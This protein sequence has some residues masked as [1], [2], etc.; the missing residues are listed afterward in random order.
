MFFLLNFEVFLEAGLAL[1]DELHIAGVLA[2]NGIAFPAFV[3]ISG[4]LGYS[5][6][7]TANLARAV[8]LDSRKAKLKM[9]AFVLVHLFDPGCAFAVD[10]FLED[11][12]LPALASAWR[13]GLIKDPGLHCRLE[14]TYL[15]LWRVITLD[16]LGQL[17]DLL[18]AL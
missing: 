1:L 12:S 5:D 18:L 6:W 16:A 15:C 7:K 11:L 2:L 9:W 8:T 14:R 10:L 3:V 17:E 13:I 4:L